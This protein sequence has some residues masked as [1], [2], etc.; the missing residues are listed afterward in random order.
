MSVE[1]G[2][3]NM[4]AQQIQKKLRTLADPA[5]AASAARFFKKEHA[6]DD[7]FLGLR[8]ATLHQLSKEYRELPINEVKSR[9]SLAT[10]AT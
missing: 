7:I 9:P 6:K 10:A 3:G 8:A 4:N 1:E 5:I 2:T